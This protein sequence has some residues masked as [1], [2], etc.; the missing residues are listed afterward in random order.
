MAKEVAGLIKL[1][2]KGG[3]ANPSPLFESTA[4]LEQ[5]PDHQKGEFVLLVEGTTTSAQTDLQ[6][7]HV[8][9]VLLEE[10]P[11]SSA[12]SLAARITGIK[13]KKLYEMALQLKDSES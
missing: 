5:N 2:I 8:L 3:A 11:V 1:Q 12:A 4:W 9:S 7:Q 6:A 13:K 10:L